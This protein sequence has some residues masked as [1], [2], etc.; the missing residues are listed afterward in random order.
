MRRRGRNESLQQLSQAI[1]RLLNGAFL[2]LDTN[3]RNG[4]AIENFKDV[5]DD[6][7]LQQAVFMA[8]PRC[9]AWSLDCGGRVEVLLAG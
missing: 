8:D 1:K 9:L 2:S 4:I 5:L 3:A 7:E 6:A